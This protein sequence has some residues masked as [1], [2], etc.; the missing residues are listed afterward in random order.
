VANDIQQEAGR[1]DL[2]FGANA[3]VLAKPEQAVYMRIHSYT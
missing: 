2:V 1:P 3:G